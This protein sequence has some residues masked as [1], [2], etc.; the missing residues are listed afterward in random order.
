MLENKIELSTIELIKNAL[1]GAYSYSEYRRIVEKLSE[2]GSSTGLNP[3]EALVNY[4]QLNHKRMK[5]WDKTFRFNEEQEKV[6]KDSRQRQLW[7]VLTESWCGDAAPSIPVMNKIS[8]LAEGI[9]LRI[10]LRDEHP[11]LMQRFLTNGAMSIPKLIAI[12]EDTYE[13]IGDW[14]PRPRKATAMVEEFKKENG[15]LTP[16]FKEGLQKWYNTDKGQSTTEDL[17]ELL[18]LK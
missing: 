18:T 8:A 12:E 3:T 1:P 2:E 6:L 10:L 7:I 11:E 13:V 16:E 14:G 15:S 5:R 9:T 4:T 17:L